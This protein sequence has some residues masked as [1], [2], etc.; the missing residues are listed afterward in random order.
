VLYPDEGRGFARPE[1]NLSFV[2]VAEAF[3]ASRLGGR[4]E[5]IG[6]DFQGASMQVPEGAHLVPGLVEALKATLN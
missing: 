4:C 6:H 5:A 2:A 1:N 3:L